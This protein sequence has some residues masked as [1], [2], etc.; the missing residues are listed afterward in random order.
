MPVWKTYQ[1]P[2]DGLAGYKVKFVFDFNSV[3]SLFNGFRGWG[4]D[5]V[6]VTN[7]M[8]DVISLPPMV[9]EID[10]TTTSYKTR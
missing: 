7:S 5:N 6:K 4:I 1:V 3:D 2:V 10:T 8:N 9:P